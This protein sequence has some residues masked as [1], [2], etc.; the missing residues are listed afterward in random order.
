MGGRIPLARYILE[1]SA[2]KLRFKD[3]ISRGIGPSRGVG[4]K[5]FWGQGE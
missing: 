2:I 1:D 5:E 4:S 3:Y